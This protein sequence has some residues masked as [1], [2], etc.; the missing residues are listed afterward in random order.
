[1]GDAFPAF[2]DF[3][4]PEPPL[5][6]AGKMEALA[7]ADVGSGGSASFSFPLPSSL[8][9]MINELTAQSLLFRY[10]FVVLMTW[11]TEKAAYNVKRWPK[12]WSF[13]DA[14]RMARRVPGAGPGAYDWGGRG[15]YELQ[16]IEEWISK[17]KDCT[18]MHLYLPLKAR[19]QGFKAHTHWVQ[20]DSPDA[21]DV[22][23]FLKLVVSFDKM[24]EAVAEFL[25][26]GSHLAPHAVAW[27]YGRALHGMCVDP[28]LSTSVPE[29]LRMPWHPLQ[30]GLQQFVCAWFLAHP[31]HMIVDNKDVYSHNPAWET[32]RLAWKRQIDDKLQRRIRKDAAGWSAFREADARRFTPVLY[33]VAQIQSNAWASRY[34]RLDAIE[35][36]K[37]Y[38][39]VC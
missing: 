3:F 31:E 4:A 21:L 29:Q 35:R 28:F 13:P 10:W 9:V 37:P 6:S 16:R 23:P 30:F 39:Y 22:E 12:G 5:P 27:R 26:L 8:T 19:H 15:F 24:V 7:S 1:M 18:D 14:E 33:T 36:A 2:E 17:W 20:L 38:F 11:Y 32:A 25:R 34:D